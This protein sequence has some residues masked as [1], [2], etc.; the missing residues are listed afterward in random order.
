MEI[1]TPKQDGNNCTGCQNCMPCPAGINI[2]KCFNLWNAKL[3]CDDDLSI[4]AQMNDLPRKPSKCFR[5]GRCEMLCPQQIQIRDD[6]EKVT[7]AFS[8]TKGI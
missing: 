5:C 3:S 6:L 7:K 8:N 1:I 4:R 2:A